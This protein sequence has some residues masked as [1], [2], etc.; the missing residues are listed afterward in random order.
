MKIV[1]KANVGSKKQQWEAAESFGWKVKG[2][3]SSDSWICA[4]ISL[5]WP[6]QFLNTGSN[7][8]IWCQLVPVLRKVV[9]TIVNDENLDIFGF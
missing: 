2:S 3:S 1:T 8:S 5:R 9:W 4:T 6:I 7:H